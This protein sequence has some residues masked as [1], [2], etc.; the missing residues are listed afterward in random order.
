[1][2]MIRE[3]PLLDYPVG[4]ADTQ[5]DED[6]LVRLVDMA[7]AYYDIARKIGFSPTA[8]KEQ[9][10]TY[11]AVHDIIA[12]RVVYGQQAGSAPKSVGQSCLS[13]LYNLH[14]HQLSSYAPVCR[15]IA[16]GAIMAVQSCIGEL[17]DIAT[18]VQA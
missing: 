14:V 15:A 7:R 16:M 4:Y 5:P 3:Q 1:M 2:Y 18:H 11:R 9:I 13:E 12:M 17:H 6:M 8:D 10:A